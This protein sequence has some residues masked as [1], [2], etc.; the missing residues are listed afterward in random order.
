MQKNTHFGAKE[1]CLGCL[2]TTC[3]YFQNLCLQ[4]HVHVA[5]AKREMKCV[6]V[7]DTRTSTRTSWFAK[8]LCSNICFD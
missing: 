2:K 7:T 4:V 5:S 1:K 6:R 3:L 8:P